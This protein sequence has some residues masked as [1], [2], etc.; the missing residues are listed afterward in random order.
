MMHIEIDISFLPQEAT[1]GQS[2]LP[3]SCD[4]H[5]QSLWMSNVAFEHVESK[6]IVFGNGQGELADGSVE[7]LTKYVADHPEKF[8]PPTV[9]CYAP[10]NFYCPF[11][12]GPKG[13]RLYLPCPAN[14]KS[15]EGS[16]DVANCTNIAGFAGL[17]GQ[18]AGPCPTGTYCP[19]GEAPSP[20]VCP[21]NT[22]SPPTSVQLTDCRAN[23]GYSHDFAGYGT[24]A[25][26]CPAD[27]YCPAASLSP[28]P[29]PGNTGA[30]P[31]SK[32]A[33]ACTA[34]AGYYGAPGTE[35]V[36]CIPDAY[37]PAG[38]VVPTPCPPNTATEA[39]GNAAAAACRAVPGYSGPYGYAA[40]R[41]PKNTFCPGASLAPSLCPSN[42]A[43]PAGSVDVSACRALA[44]FYGAWGAAA[45][46]VSR[47]RC[48]PAA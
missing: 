38:S 30:P 2:R 20:I 27:T 3:C 15:P 42:T 43:S 31:R 24:P 44:G 6:P 36:P 7:W 17:P 23:P 21:A 4:E 35:A 26:A 13:Y 25:S 32:A 10:A 9:P 34:L 29:C 46:P 16:N 41:C 14:T 40:A 45:V 12:E 19:D 18:A 48:R 5:F 37:C 47:R 28:T 39:G 33:T 11:P 8:R 1:S 22:G